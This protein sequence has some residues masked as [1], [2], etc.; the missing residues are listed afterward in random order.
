MKPS[1][2]TFGSFTQRQHI[3][4]S[5]PVAPH[6]SGLSQLGRPAFSPATSFGETA[7]TSHGAGYKDITFESGGCCL[8]SRMCLSQLIIENFTAVPQWYTDTTDDFG[9]VVVASSTHMTGTSTA[10]ASSAGTTH[11]QIARP[12]TGHRRYQN[13]D[14]TRIQTLRPIDAGDTFSSIFV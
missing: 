1:G 7:L 3:S 4:T 14:T 8:I 12:T 9:S 13:M 11:V 5:G 6:P 10:P 2:S